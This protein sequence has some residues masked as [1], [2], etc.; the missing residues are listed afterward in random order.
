VGFEGIIN[1]SPLR[2]LCQKAFPASLNFSPE[3]LNIK[4]RNDHGNVLLLR[5]VNTSEEVKNQEELPKG[6]L[7]RI[8]QPFLRLFSKQKKE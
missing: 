7:S 3:V 6:I 8:F 1:L 2:A 4:L 5:N